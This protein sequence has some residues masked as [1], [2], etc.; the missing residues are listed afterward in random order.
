MF[1]IKNALGAVAHSFNPALWE[2]KAGGSLE[3]RTS[4]LA[5]PIGETPPLLK[6]SWAWWLAPVIPATPEAEV[7]GLLAPGRSRLP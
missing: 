3:V 6:I 1:I 2:A 4:R 7:G 5:W